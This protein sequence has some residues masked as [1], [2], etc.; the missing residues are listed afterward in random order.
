[1]VYVVMAPVTWNNILCYTENNC[2]VYSLCV[3]EDTTNTWWG[4]MPHCSLGDTSLF[5]RYLPDI[6]LGGG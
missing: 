1:M 5:H 3:Q 2:P 4:A 6:W